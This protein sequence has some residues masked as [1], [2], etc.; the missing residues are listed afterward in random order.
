MVEHIR[1]TAIILSVSSI[2]FLISGILLISLSDLLVKKTVNRECQLKQ[3][4]IIYN[5]WRNSPVPFYISIY[6]FDLAN[7]ADFL[8][9]AKPNLIQHGPFV[10]KEQRTKEDVKFYP[11]GTISYRESRNYTFDR[12]KSMADETLSITTINIVYMV[13]EAQY[14]TILISSGVGL[15]ENHIERINNLGRI[16]RFNFSTNLSV[17][18]NKYANMI[19]GT[20]STIWHPDVKKDEFIYT[21]MNDICRSVHL[22]YNQTHKNL[23]D[24]DTYHYIL[25][26]DA[27]AN[28]K[29]NE[30]F[31]L[32]NTMENGTQQLKC[33]PSGL[34][35]LSSC[36]HLSGS[37]IA[38]PLPIIASNPHFLD[39][40]RSIQDAV[41]GLIPDDISHRS[42][43]D[44]EPTTGIIMNGSR[45]MQFNINVVNDSKIDA[46]SHI[47]P[48]VYPMIWV[49]EHAEIDQP[50]ADIFHK[51]VYVPLLLLTV[52]KY[53]IIAIGTTLLITVISLVVFSRYKKNILAAPEPTTITDE[54][55]PLLV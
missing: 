42:Y 37:S 12:S 13:N 5:I 22:K 21:F 30:G 17:W 54:T 28:S 23:F 51:K 50:N 53:V 36:V 27:F 24:I 43:M 33:L 26:N 39:S 35:S 16:E 45:R 49:D 25:P 48:L 29:D 1:C 34:F 44:L 2:V 55:T 40:D 4:T 47:H 32:N 7:K 6:V 10:Y 41:D 46:I 18:S 9:G 31:C 14:E 3:G 11:N 20:D 52:F 15:D 38:I 8:N 19:N